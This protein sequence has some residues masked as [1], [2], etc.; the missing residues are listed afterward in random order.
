M[1]TPAGFWVRVVAA[2]VDT[3]ILTVA[4]VA[5]VALI[6]SENY[7]ASSDMSWGDLL[8]FLLDSAY[9]TVAVAAWRTTIAKRLLGLY[10]VRADGSR[11]GVGRALARSLATYLSAILLGFGF[12]MVAFRRDKRGLHDLICDTRVVR[13]RRDEATR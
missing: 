2:V 9:F 10:V 13:M 8:A 7:L 4:V 3:L 5:L 11:V 1:G 12:L 6:F